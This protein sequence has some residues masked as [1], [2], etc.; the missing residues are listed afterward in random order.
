MQAGHLWALEPKAMLNYGTSIIYVL[1][2]LF[3]FIF[4]HD[5]GWYKYLVGSGG[6]SKRAD[7]L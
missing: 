5:F 1:F 7:M 3:H 4:F 2:L 6:A